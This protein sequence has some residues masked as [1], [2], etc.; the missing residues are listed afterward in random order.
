MISQKQEILTRRF[1]FHSF[2][3]GQEEVMDALLT[4]RDALAVMPTGS[5]K[6]L[7]FQIPALLFGGLSLV[8]SP[9]ISLMKDQVNALRASGVSAAFLNS[10]L[11]GSQMYRVLEGACRGEFSLLYVAPERLDTEAFQRLTSQIA[12]P[13]VAVDEAHCVSQW[14][15]DFRPSYL[16]IESFIRSL[17][18]RPVLGAFTAT[19]TPRVRQDIV[20]LLA[21]SKP[22]LV[23]TGFDRSNLSFEV[24][25]PEDKFQ[26]LAAFLADRPRKSGIIYCLTRKTVDTLSEKLCSQGYEAVSYHAGL[27]RE[28]RQAN[29]DRFQRDDARIMVATNAFG[30]GID[31]SNVHYVFH[32]NMPKDMESYYQEAGRAG[33]DG[34]PAEC[35]LLHDMRDLRINKFLIEKD[36]EN[37]EL[38]PEELERLQKAQKQRLRRMVEYCHSTSCLRR[39]ILSYFGENPPASCGNCGNCLR[40]VNLQ[41]ITIDAQKILSCVKRMKERYG[42]TLLMQTL[43]GSRSKKVLELEFDKL[44]TYGIMRQESERSLRRKIDFLLAREYMELTEDDFPVLRTT[45]LGRDVLFRGARVT[46]PFGEEEARPSLVRTG[47]PGSSAAPDPEE[48]SLFERLR[49][50]RKTL[51]KEEGVPAFVIFSDATLRDLSAKRPRNLEELLDVEGIGYSKRAKYGE[52]FLKALEEH[53]KA[54]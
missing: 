47:S 44:S 28:E 19:A 16:R 39:E 3:E 51:A 48:E 31:K 12:I 36:R 32:Y 42:L 27:T 45:S 24:H 38:D 7:C 21:L 13:F 29:Q 5:G 1:G 14:G 6:S 8:I 33:R 10:A 53:A 49:E 46:M 9:L 20:D 17:P 11:S 22:R 25:S 23:T 34:L 54:G 30:M 15:Q 37:Q 18:S 50:L 26:A 43:R 41:D 40:K 35:V 52:A 4:G 2:R